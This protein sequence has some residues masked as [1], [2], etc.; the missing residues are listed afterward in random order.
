MPELSELLTNF[1]SAVVQFQFLRPW[2]LLAVVPALLAAIALHRSRSHSSNWSR[3]ISPQLLP[4]LLDDNS[5]HSN[6][7]KLPFIA[8]V[9]WLFAAFALSGPSWKDIPVPIQKNE[10]ALVILLD[11]SPSMLAEDMKP[12][13]LVR[14]RLKLLDLLQARNEG[15]SAL[16][17]YAGNAHVVTPLTD[18]TRTIAALVPALAPNIMPISGNAPE[19]AVEKALELLANG[20]HQSGDILMISDGLPESAALAISKQLKANDGIT[21]SVLGVGTAEGAPIPE[22]AGGFYKDRNGN[23]VIARYHSEELRKLSNRHQGIYVELDN[24]ERDIKRIQ[25]F[26][27]NKFNDT[28]NKSN[29]RQ[30]E[31]TFD[32]REDNGHWFALLLLPFAILAFRRNLLAL[33]ILL[34]LFASSP[35]ASAFEWDELWLRADQRGNKAFE[36]GD[37]ATAQQQFTDPDWQASA[38]YRNGDYETATELFEKNT[39]ADGHYNRG[40]SLAQTGNYDEAIAAYDQALQLDPELKDAAENRKLIEA[41]KQQKQEQEQEQQNQ[42]SSD[43]KNSDSKSSDSQN[44]DSKDTNSESTDE[45]G[46]DSNSK[47]QQNAQDTPEE[48]SQNNSE[49]GSDNSSEN[50]PEKNQGNENQNPEDTNKQNN[51]AGKDSNQDNE[52]DSTATQDPQNSTPEPKTGNSENN[53]ATSISDSRSEE[54][55]Q[56]HEQWLRS[57]PDDPGSLMRR[58]FL[59]EAQTRPPQSP[60]PT[61]DERW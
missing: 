47:S 40:N 11:L 27:D 44:S 51:A 23:I 53:P 36:E 46:Q 17:A 43:S 19:L 25:A 26:F 12:N 20:G 41:L 56:A 54:Q 60:T 24:G 7:K 33:V 31:R 9:L 8:F 4:W 57:L 45:E 61:G 42:D 34:P 58:K 10:Q 32:M 21:L 5:T 15:V 48:N 6:T 1:S 37:P 50:S 49:D 28:L 3:V 18:D 35:P 22:K 39:S 14:A 16:I 29:M 38:A 13:R 2:W 55:K 30:L 52:Q 59:Y